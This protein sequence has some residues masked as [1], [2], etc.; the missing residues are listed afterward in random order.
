[1][2]LHWDPAQGQPS[3]DAAKNLF[4]KINTANGTIYRSDLFGDTR[5]FEMRFTTIR[6]GASCW[7]EPRISMGECWVTRICT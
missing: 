5:E 2:Q 6:W 3:I 7:A 1:V 4:D